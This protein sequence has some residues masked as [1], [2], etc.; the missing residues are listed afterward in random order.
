MQIYEAGN[1]TNLANLNFG[2]L[3]FNIRLYVC[4]K[5]HKMGSSITTRHI[6]RHSD[7]SQKRVDKT[8]TKEQTQLLKSKGWA[9]IKPFMHLNFLTISLSWSAL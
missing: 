7:Y 4:K 5:Q 2:Y 6:P 3:M 8:S 1:C 9:E